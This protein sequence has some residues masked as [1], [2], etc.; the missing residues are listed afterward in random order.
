MRFKPL[1]LA[2]LLLSPPLVAEEE[3]A[4]PLELLEY[5]GGWEDE[6][7]NWLDPLTLYGAALELAQA[8][9]ET[10]DEQDDN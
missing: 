9:S 7:G 1:V 5:L 6:Q 3:A 4:P 2:L 10:N 8:E